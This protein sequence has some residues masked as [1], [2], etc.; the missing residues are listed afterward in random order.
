[1]R[2]LLQV[3]SHANEPA[4]LDPISPRANN[5]P[6]YDAS[7]LSELKAST[8]TAR[9]SQPVYDIS[10]DADASMNDITMGD[11]TMDPMDGKWHELMSS[12]AFH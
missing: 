4:S 3:S 6:T 5:G 10:Y 11:I 9:P 7:Y 2:D 12:F 8:P 1:M